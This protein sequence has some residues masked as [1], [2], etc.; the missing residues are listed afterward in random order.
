[1]QQIQADHPGSSRL[2]I[3]FDDSVASL[4]LPVNATFGDIAHS[5][6]RLPRARC[7]WPVTIAITLNRPEF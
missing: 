3:V 2:R 7:R 4:N 1:M 6:N 5:L